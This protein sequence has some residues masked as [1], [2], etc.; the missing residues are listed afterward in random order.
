MIR[1]QQQ[2]TP[3]IQRYLAGLRF[4]GDLEL[5]TTEHSV[6]FG[7]DYNLRKF[8][9]NSSFASQFDVD[10]FDPFNPVYGQT[11]N[12]VAPVASI[13]TEEKQVGFYLNDHI[14]FNEKWS[15]VLGL[16]S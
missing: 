8:K 12:V 5:G 4:I 1:R 11:T 2:F 16:E 15:A 7:M 13:D 10:F 9:S 6:V 14:T 3:D